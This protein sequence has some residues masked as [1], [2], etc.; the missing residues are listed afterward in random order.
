MDIRPIVTD[1]DYE[2]A[3]ADIK[4]LWSAPAGSP[5]AQKMEMLA[6]LAHN[7]ERAREP[8]PRANPIEAIKFRM[9]QQG[10][11]RKDLLPIFGTT[12]R[13]SE[14]LSGKRSLT[15]DMVRNLHFGLGIPLE[16]LVTQERWRAKPPTPR[17][18][19][20]SKRQHRQHRAAPTIP[21]TRRPS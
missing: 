15:L 8:L 3:L 14:V 10:L 16:S 13:I 21:K 20:Q 7:Y 1:K 17:R 4:R 12:A 2:A 5:E 11:S 9:D 19:V 18:K 6:M